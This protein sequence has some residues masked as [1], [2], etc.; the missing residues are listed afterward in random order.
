MINKK[1]KYLLISI[2]LL[3][4][5]NINVKANTTNNIDFNKLGTISL[6]LKENIEEKP[7]TG[8][9]ITIYQVATATT[10]DYNLS[11]IFNDNIKNCNLDLS[12]ISDNNLANKIDKCIESLEL[13]TITKTTNEEGIAIFNNLELGLYL[14]KETNNVYGYSNIDPF[15]VAIPT[16]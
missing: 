12:D 8:A 9:N 1:I 10:K 13:E 16:L 6:T 3:S 5:A 4:I 15:L 7:I 2:I 14:V 11:Y